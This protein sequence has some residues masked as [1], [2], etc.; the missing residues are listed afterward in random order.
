[1]TGAVVG[2]VLREVQRKLATRTAT[3]AGE[4]ERA[5]LGRQADQLRREI[6]RL[7]DAI[8]STA[9][10]PQALVGMMGEREAQLAALEKRIAHLMRRSAVVHVAARQLEKE[11]RARLDGLAALA[12]RNLEGARMV[13]AALLRKPLELEPSNY[14]H[15]SPRRST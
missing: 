1:M 10:T 9:E 3:G 2:E 8:V 11:R 13:L 5:E 14:C 4:R 12:Q 6:Q 7:G 15:I